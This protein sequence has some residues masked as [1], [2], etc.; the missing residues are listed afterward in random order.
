MRR[1]LSDSLRMVFLLTVPSSVGLVLLGESII[2]AIYEGG[3]F[4]PYDTHQTAVALS[5]Y[6][7][8]LAGYSAIKVLNPAFYALGDARTP[9]VI[10]M[11]SIAINYSAVAVMT[12]MAGLGHA[13]LALSTSIVAL[14][15]FVSLFLLLRGRIGGLYGRD[16]VRAFYK[17]IAASLVMAAVVAFSSYL[18]HMAMGRTRP[19][20]FVDLAISIPAGLAAYYFACRAQNISEID[21]AVQAFARPFLRRL[22]RRTK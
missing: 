12:T 9:M 16:L 20:H 22:N 14:F 21:M 5:F 13:G 7:I 10:S 4:Q 1:T 19:A 15:S 2:G 3:K 8:G 11:L 6:A 18:V 17:V